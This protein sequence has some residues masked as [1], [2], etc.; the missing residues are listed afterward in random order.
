MK[1]VYPIGTTLYRPEECFNGYTLISGA[2]AVKLVDMNGRTAHEWLVAPDKAK[3]FIHRARLMPDGRL[4]LLFGPRGANLAHVEEFGW[5]GSL[6]WQYTPEDGNP[7]HDFSS[8]PEGNV[9]LLCSAPVPREVVE[10]I[11]DPVRRAMTIHGDTII[12]VSRDKQVVWRW[13]QH[14]YLDINLCNPIPANRQ[15]PG[16]PDNNTITDW[17]HTNTVQSLPENRWF[18]QGDERFRPGNVLISMRQLDTILIVDRRTSAVVW[19]YTGTF[20]G[21]MSGQ[22]ESVMIEKPLPGAGNILVFDN[23]ASPYKDLAHS[24]RSFVIE[25][26]P[27]SGEVVWFYE[28]G[29][30]FYSPFTSNCQRLANGNTLILE[31]AYRRLFEVT[32]EGKIVWEHITTDNAHRVYRYPYDYCPQAR[33]LPRPADVPVTPPTE[34][35]IPPDGGGAAID[36]PASQTR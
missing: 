24:G 13:R 5:D 32:A 11:K 14:E 36:A 7:H 6:L 19:S 28:D 33:E 16:G 2:G 22:H 3:G 20:R 30:K 25:V 23:G 9:L 12:E 29:H 26:D 31:A 17:T 4:M 15:W 18:D 21:G 10:T 1:T 35:R 34:L 27:P 8:T